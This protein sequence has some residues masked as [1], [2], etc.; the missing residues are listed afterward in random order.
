MNHAYRLVWNSTTQ[1][2]VP[3]AEHARA[4]GRQGGGKAARL[5]VAALLAAGGGTV[6]ALPADGRVTAGQGSVS[7]SGNTMTVNQQS[8]KLALDWRSFGIAA[9]ETVKFVQPS[10]SAVAL[11]RVIGSDPSAI[12]GNLQANGQVF[13]INPN[14]ILFAPGAQVNVGGLVAST[15]DLSNTDFL[16]GKF[17]FRSGATA[18]ASVVNQGSITASP[19]G[20]VALLGGT[21]SNQGLIAARLGTVALAGGAGVTLDF[22]G[23]RL[24]NLQVD[25]A[26]L[27]A[28]AENR[29]LIQA[30]GGLVVMTAAARD[31]LLATVVNNSGVIEARSVENRNGVIKLLGD[32]MGGTAG[33][34][35]HV[36]GTLDAS[37]PNGGDG[38]FIETSGAHVKVAEGTVITTAAP[39]GA[40]GTWLIDPADYTIAAAGGDISG[41]TLSSNLASTSVSIL[42]SNGTVNTAGNGD[43]F[44]N[45]AVTWSSANTLTLQAVRN[46]N[47]NAAINGAGGGLILN[48]ANAISAP[49]AVN[50]GTFTLQAGNWSQLGASLPVFAAAN[51]RL[52]GGS[53]LRALGGDGSAATPYLLA[54]IYGVQ[55]MGSSAAMLS[56]NYAL[57]G[58]VDATGTLNW[59]SSAGFKPIGDS[60]T[61]FTGSLDGQ[62]HA[63]NNLVIS[64]TGSNYVGLFG[65]LGAGSTVRNLAL[66]GGSVKGTNQVGA[67][68]GY[69]SGTV[70]NTYAT[71]AV[72]GS[73]D[74]GGLVGVNNGTMSRSHA[75]GAVTSS[76]YGGGLAG[77]IHGTM[78]TVYATGA[79]RSFFSGGLVGLNDGTINLA[80]A[81]GSVRGF[82]GVGGLVGINSLGSISNA[83]ATGAVTGTNIYAG[84]L[85]G[86]NQSGT[87]SNTYASGLVTGVNFKAGLIGSNDG[88]AVVSNSYWDTQ[89]TGQTVGI[90]G[91][92]ATGGA[93]GMT[94]AA[95]MSQATY[96]GYDF[97]S[98]WTIYQGHTY[99]L[100]RAFMT[101]LTVTAANANKTYDGLAWS[102]GNGLS[103]PAGANPALVLG[104]PVYGGNS[105]GAKNVGAYTLSVSGLYSTQ[106]GYLISYANGAL[107]I[108][109]KTIT[110]NASAADKAYDGTTAASVTLASAGV[111]AG[112]TLNF[113]NTGASFDNK[114]A[115]TGKTVSVTGISASGA[116]T[117][118]YLLAG[119]SATTTASV[120]PKTITV[121]ATGIDKVY[122]GSTGASVTIAGSGLIAGDTVS[123]TNSGASFAD[124][125][126][127]TGK[128]VA[129]TGI[130]AAGTDGGN[131]RVGNPGTTTSANITPATLTVSGITAA[132]KV[133]DGTTVAVVSTAGAVVGGLIGGDSV[134]IGASGTFSDKNAGNGK[135][136]NLSTSSSGADAGNYSITGQTGTTASITP[137][138]L[139]YTANPASF[140]TGQTPA[141]LSG[142]LGGF[143]GADTLANST[144]GSP[145]WNTPASA[146]SP[147]G[148]YA[149]LGAGVTANQGN[150]TFRQAAGN[151]TALTLTPAP[152]GSGSGSGSGSGTTTS[153]G[154]Q[155]AV[156]QVLA[157]VY[158]SITA[159]ADPGSGVPVADS[160]VR[161]DHVF[162]APPPP[163][164]DAGD[165]HQAVAE[166]GRAA[167][168][169]PTTGDATA[170]PCAKPVRAPGALLRL[171]D[172]GI[173][174]PPGVG[175]ED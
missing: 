109:P 66:V 120:T 142:Q 115:G 158:G 6:H 110:V 147:A 76:N 84:G 156:G 138:T 100:L 68:A 25:Q 36:G 122:D 160:G 146:A 48:A 134:I 11:N 103:L 82:A 119:T 34:S 30:D 27:G 56:R 3:A 113:A 42:S 86:Y 20:Y 46:V 77:E 69:S 31:A 32:A 116:S 1:S 9:G 75:T 132:N 37:A 49:A 58:D 88:T 51:F 152:P 170:A 7:S 13:L 18:P 53:F 67:L 40:A 136:V 129:V 47:I 159:V 33:G 162:S 154:T 153:T 65:D 174:L 98:T 101:P 124:K 172:G 149:I 50:V 2:H 128:A 107:T 57:A 104:T 62:G 106:Q 161:S 97:S 111:V 12:Y 81:S 41:A 39:R 80:Y 38:G 8:G 112:D 108:N 59:N 60:T 22:D 96:G 44:V 171:L 64:R 141:G 133:Y 140:A 155:Q 144:S 17:K 45:D 164:A 150:Y 29:Q 72:T 125:N 95:A 5:L 121:S 54:D 169:D 135:T 118:N 117:G 70:D 14:G 114:N 73:D 92:V 89:S 4:R 102:G 127:G 24:V 83:Y 79:V 43:I 130:V 126:V 63:I 85:V 123:F 168:S 173:R 163:C 21:A 28:L 23:N 61:T 26:A 148:Q 16:A 137:A 19:G 166:R 94:T 55:G 143:V 78:S 87:I 165:R 145:Q 52:Q 105:Q 151:A 90:A 74:V 93:T 99:G 15:L 157:G 91:T 71:G 35:V 139:T 131:Y 167:G 10:A 175:T